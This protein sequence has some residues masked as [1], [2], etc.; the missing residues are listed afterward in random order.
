VKKERSEEKEKS[1]KK[2]LLETGPSTTGR[3]EPQGLPPTK[4]GRDSA[5]LGGNSKRKSKEKEERKERGPEKRKASKKKGDMR[6][7]RGG[8]WSRV[9]RERG[10]SV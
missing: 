7:A 2:N 10:R 1:K 9:L 4:G 8:I 6:G 5:S 3:K